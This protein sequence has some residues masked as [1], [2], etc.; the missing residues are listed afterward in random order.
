[1][2]GAP[3]VI[4]RSLLVTIAYEMVALDCM[5]AEQGASLDRRVRSVAL[6]RP[7]APSAAG[8]TRHAWI[9]AVSASASYGARTLTSLSK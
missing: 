1:M 2:S 3:C 4:H 9:R 5:L 8:A 6:G 7:Q